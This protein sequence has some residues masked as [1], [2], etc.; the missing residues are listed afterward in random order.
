MN[1]M[2]ICSNYGAPW[3]ISDLHEYRRIYGDPLLN[4][5]SPWLFMDIYNQFMDVNSFIMEINNSMMEL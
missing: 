2:S 1:V 4:Y 3:Y 5:G